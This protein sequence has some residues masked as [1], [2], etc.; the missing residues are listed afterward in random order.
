[1]IKVNGFSK[2][3]DGIEMAF[4]SPALIVHIEP[5]TFAPILYFRKP[6]WLTD[7]QYKLVVADVMSQI[8]GLT[9]ETV[10]ALETDTTN[11]QPARGDLQ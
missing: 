5:N 6:S 8:K 4:K 11:I 10:D 7:K 3:K 2:T 1:M 9:Q